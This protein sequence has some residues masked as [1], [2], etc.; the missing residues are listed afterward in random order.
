MCVTG[1]DLRG[2][3]EAFVHSPTAN[4]TDSSGKHAPENVSTTFTKDP[5]RELP[6]KVFCS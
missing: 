5:A 4:N 2:G 6:A 3:V 1:E